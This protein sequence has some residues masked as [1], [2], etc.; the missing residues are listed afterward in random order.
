MIKLLLIL[1]GFLPFKNADQMAKYI[2]TV[3]EYQ[4]EMVAF[5][6]IP[7]NIQYCKSPHKTAHERGG[8]CEDLATL[9]QYVLEK[10]GYYTQLYRCFGRD[11]NHIVCDFQR[12]DVNGIISNTNVYYNISIG[13][14]ITKY[15][16]DAYKPYT[17]N[18]E[19]YE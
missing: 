15:R 2:N 3:R 14:Y 18:W 13:E 12:G 11:V 17:T 16:Y 8:D 10:N 1:C 5:K 19:D 9:A 4:N 7:D 6:H